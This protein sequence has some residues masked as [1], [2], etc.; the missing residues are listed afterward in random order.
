MAKVVVDPITRIE[1]HLRVEAQ[2]QGGKVADAWSSSTMFRGLELI[3]KGR[4]P[5][6]AWLFAQ[7]I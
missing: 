2:V 4:D 1:G 7:R 6:D 3:L 5:R